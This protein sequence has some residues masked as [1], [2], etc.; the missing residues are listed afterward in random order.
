M[1][2]KR[3]G[4]HQRRSNVEIKELP[5]GK[6]GSGLQCRVFD[7]FSNEN[8]FFAQEKPRFED[9]AREIIRINWPQRNR[10]SLRAARRD[11]RVLSREDVFSAVIFRLPERLGRRRTLVEATVPVI[12]SAMHSTSPNAPRRAQGARSQAEETL[13]RGANGA[14]KVRARKRSAKRFVASSLSCCSE[15][16]GDASDDLPARSMADFCD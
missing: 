2:K 12:T 9:L 15:G 3:C 10:R 8:G 13:M 6:I 4:E 7:S 14:R 1:R 5:P 11:A 16:L